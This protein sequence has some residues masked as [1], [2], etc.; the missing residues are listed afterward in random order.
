MLA[1]IPVLTWLLDGS[2][3]PPHGSVLL[4]AAKVCW[5]RYV[6]RLLRCHSHRVNRPHSSPRLERTLERE[7]RVTSR[8]DATTTLHYPLPL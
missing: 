5:Q 7:T 1:P 3:R 4:V 2:H 8:E 6:H